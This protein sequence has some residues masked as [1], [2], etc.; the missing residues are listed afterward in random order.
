[1]SSPVWGLRFVAETL[2]GAP[3]HHD[4]I[5]HF[6]DEICELAGRYGLQIGGGFRALNPDEPLCGDGTP[7][8]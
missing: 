4:T 5:D 6:M 3:V 8:Q 1:M 2:S 7:P